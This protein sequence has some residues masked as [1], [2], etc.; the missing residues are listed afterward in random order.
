MN[1]FQGDPKL[2][3]DEDGADLKFQ[4]GQPVM[5][6][7]V[8]NAVFMSLHTREGWVGNVFATSPSEKMGSKFEE[9]MDQPITLASLGA[10]RKAALDALQW[11]IDTKLAASVSVEVSNPK[12]SAIK[13]TITVTP[14]SGD[15]IV[16]LSLKH[17]VN[18]VYQKLEPAYER[19]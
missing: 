18:W 14:P 19:I 11:M 13:T 5:D 9:L 16:L 12:G 3:L 6:R 2:I 1:R 8:E 10:I 17:G 4:G 15:A 7:G